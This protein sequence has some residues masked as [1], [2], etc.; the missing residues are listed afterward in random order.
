MN[1]RFD[2]TKRALPPWS[3]FAARVLKGFGIAAVLVG[4]ALT[5]GAWGYHYFEGRPWL[6]AFLNAA[7]ILTGMGPVDKVQ[8]DGGKVFAIGYALLSGVIFLTVFAVLLGPV[9][10]RFLHRFHLDFEDSDDQ[11]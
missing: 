9:F 2:D 8:T 5:F 6:D 1:Q 11:R 10:H 3:H 7:M 4:A